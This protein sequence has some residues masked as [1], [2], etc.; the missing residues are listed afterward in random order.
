MSFAASIAVATDL[1]E[2]SHVALIE[3][4]RLARA[5]ACPV[6]LLHVIE[7]P[8]WLPEQAENLRLRIAEE[9]HGATQ[10]VLWSL[11]ER[12]F[13]GIDTVTVRSV[14]HESVVQGVC[15]VVDEVGAD[16]LVVASHG[17]AGASG[18]T[19]QLVRQAPCRLLVVPARERLGFALKRV[20][21]A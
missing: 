17:R 1:S 5:A 7:L 13:D 2:A 8:A 3:A 11:R 14:E 9:A 19:E 20:V 18:V 10:S 6:T 12:L 15:A 16:L 21:C 4:A